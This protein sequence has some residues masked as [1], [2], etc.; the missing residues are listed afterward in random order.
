M[1]LAMIALFPLTLAGNA[2][3]DP[4]TMPG[5]LRAVVGA[6]PVTHLVTATNGA[7]TTGQVAGVLLTALAVT[8]VFAPLTRRAYQ[9]KF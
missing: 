8:A 7:A 1:S 9:R 4:H 3:V 6:N 2:F 5:W